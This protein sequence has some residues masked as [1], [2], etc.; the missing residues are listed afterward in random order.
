MWRANAVR[1]EV[2]KALPLGRSNAVSEYNTGVA[3]LRENRTMNTSH[4]TY[5]A[6][7]D[8]IVAATKSLG[9][10]TDRF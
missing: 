5:R 1:T 10:A 2:L 7:A 3:L 9:K 6:L 8:A 4:G